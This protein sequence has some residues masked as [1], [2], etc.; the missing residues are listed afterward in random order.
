M[1]IIL[2]VSFGNSRVHLLSRAAKIGQA[3]VMIIFDDERVLR[4]DDA[5]AFAATSKRRTS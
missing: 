3:T 2:I 4:D 1:Q 5:E